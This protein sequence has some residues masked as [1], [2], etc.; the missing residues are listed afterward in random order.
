MSFGCKRRQHDRMLLAHAESN[1]GAAGAGT[2]GDAAGTA[3]RAVALTLTAR[4]TPEK[5]REVFETGA[6][7]QREQER[8]QHVHARSDHRYDCQARAT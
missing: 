4:G 5:E 8:E 1:E 3:G 7:T 6:V 2:D